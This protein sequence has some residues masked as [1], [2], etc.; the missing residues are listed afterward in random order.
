MNRSLILVGTALTLTTGWLLHG[1]PAIESG[2]AS[3]SIERAIASSLTYLERDGDR[4]M[5]GEISIQRGVGCVS[6]HHVGYALWSHREAQRAGIAPASVERIDDLRR[7][8]T[9]SLVQIAE[10]RVVSATQM[11]LADAH[12]EHDLA[13]IRDELES[14]GHWRARGQF[15]TQIRGEQETDATM[16]LWALVAL[17]SLEEIDDATRKRYDRALEWLAAA[18]PGVSS[19]WTFA[20][21]IVASARHE[22]AETEALLERTLASQREDGGWG[23]LPGDESNAFSTGQALYA[24]ATLDDARGDE[25]LRRG[26]AYLLAR[27]LPDGSWETASELTST[28]PSKG[29]DYIY[30]YWGTAWASIGLSRSLARFDPPS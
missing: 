26:V 18:E 28:A 30:R 8:A 24:L 23:W 21:M 7:R 4:W 19:E 12:G 22:A 5:K 16:S 2:G 17:E 11:I 9:E 3:P 14:A 20:R 15:S 6:C 1:A 29:K 25:A 10:A 13:V 27:Q